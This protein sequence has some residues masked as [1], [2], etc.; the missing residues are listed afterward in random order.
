MSTTRFF[1]QGEL[2]DT[3]AALTCSRIP[4]TP[5]QITCRGASVKRNPQTGSP[6][7]TKSPAETIN[8]FRV[9]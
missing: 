2:V 6:E 5:Q 7:C 9:P 3:R 4:K 8:Q 1:P